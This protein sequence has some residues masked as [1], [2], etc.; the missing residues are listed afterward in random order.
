VGGVV[1]LIRSI[2]KEAGRL[3]CQA[4]EEFNDEP[5]MEQYN[6]FDDPE[7]LTAYLEPYQN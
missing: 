5:L 2:E 7:D 3:N 6:Q 1:Y 4:P